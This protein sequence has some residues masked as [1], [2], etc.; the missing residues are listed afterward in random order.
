[1]TI[2]HSIALTLNR[3]LAPFDLHLGR[4]SEYPFKSLS[5]ESNLK[6]IKI[7]GIDPATIID[8]GASDGRWTEK[9][10]KHFPNSYYFLIEA[11]SIHET[12]LAEF[13][14]KHNNCAFKITAAAD[15]VGEIY[16]D[17]S[18]PFT[19]I[20]SHEGNNQHFIEVSCTTIDEEVAKNDLKG[21]Y[22]LKL[23]THGFEV[24]IFNGAKNTLQETSVVIVETYNFELTKGSLKFWEM[25]EFLETL[26]FRPVDIMEPMFRP[27]DQ[28]L[29]Q[30]DLVF[31]RSDRDEFQI[32][33]YE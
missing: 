24:P 7:K 26:G 27:K 6:R 1:M 19:G 14:K 21:P 11:N 8:I 9:V 10:M 2:K 20:A 25:C 22:L 31:I 12:N 30:M 4:L 17:S 15:S 5:L 3:L 28:A 32:N 29:W 33:T 13:V 23:D 18:D 16:F